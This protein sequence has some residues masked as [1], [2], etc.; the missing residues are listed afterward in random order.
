MQFRFLQKMRRVWEEDGGVIG[1]FVYFTSDGWVD[2]EVAIQGIKQGRRFKTKTIMPSAFLD[3]ASVILRK[4]LQK[5]EREYV[6]EVCQRLTF[7]D[8]KKGEFVTRTSE[9]VEFWGQE[10]ANKLS[11]YFSII[12]KLYEFGYISKSLN[13]KAIGGNSDNTEDVIFGT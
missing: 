4:S 8:I 10:A 2:R 6:N 3:D 13:S 1:R 7:E 12:R 11:E 5:I 9:K